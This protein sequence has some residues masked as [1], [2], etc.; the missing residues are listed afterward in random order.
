MNNRRRLRLRDSCASRLRRWWLLQLLLLP[1][2]IWA[3]ARSRKLSPSVANGILAIGCHGTPY[4]ERHSTATCV[5]NL[6]E[7]STR[8][9]EHI[10]NFVRRIESMI[11]D[12]TLNSNRNRLA[13][14][15]EYSFRRACAKY[16]RI[17]WEK[18]TEECLS[19]SITSSSLSLSLSHTDRCCFESRNHDLSHLL[20]DF[21]AQWNE[22][23]VMRF[24]TAQVDSL[25]NNWLIDGYKVNGLNILLWSSQNRMQT[26]ALI[27]SANES[28]EH[29]QMASR[30]DKTYHHHQSDA[31]RS[32]RNHFCIQNTNTTTTTTERNTLAVDPHK[33]RICFIEKV[34]PN[35]NCS[36]KKNWKKARSGCSTKKKSHIFDTFLCAP[37]W[38]EWKKKP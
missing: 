4:V 35:G 36:C 25:T 23:I 14:M 5:Q 1:H 13:K 22:T 2:L 24:V 38:I 9:S 7:F 20:C 3:N 34:V 19:L 18:N 28:C 37:E 12:N 11:F 29:L 30:K 27:H 17:R 26:A 16:R 31:L 33:V 21:K 6:R 10:I 15:R 8:L 32:T